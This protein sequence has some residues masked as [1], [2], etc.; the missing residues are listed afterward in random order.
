MVWFYTSLVNIQKAIY[1]LVHFRAVRAT[2]RGQVPR[3]RMTSLCYGKLYKDKNNV[4]PFMGH[5]GYSCCSI[6]SRLG[7]RRKG[8]SP[9]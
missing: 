4:I 8:G 7:K 3:T 6:E 1:F 2:G 9:S 5:E